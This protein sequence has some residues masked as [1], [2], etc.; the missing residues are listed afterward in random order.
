MHCACCKNTKA[1]DD[2]A[3]TQLNAAYQSPLAPFPIA[4]CQKY[5]T[6]LAYPSY[7]MDQAVTTAPYLDT[8]NNMPLPALAEGAASHGT[9]QAVHNFFLP[10]SGLLSHAQAPAT[11][12]WSMDPLHSASHT[13]PLTTPSVPLVDGNGFS[14]TVGYA[15]V[16]LPPQTPRCLLEAG[17]EDPVIADT[18]AITNSD[19]V[20]S[21]RVRCNI[22]N[23]DFGKPN[24][25]R[26]HQR[27]VH[28]VGCSTTFQCVCAY[29]N[30]RKDNFIRH[31][32]RCSDA[33]AVYLYYACICQALFEDKKTYVDHVVSCR[34]NSL[35][36]G[37]RSANRVCGSKTIGYGAAV[38]NTV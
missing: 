25:L 6:P 20:L 4:N 30:V 3:A 21:S 35:R 12:I 27:Q 2:R 15:P 31:L 22:C 29:R 7:Q 5:N 1:M 32:R 19:T 8:P 37:R 14:D 9:M 10:P 28:G 33:S 13:A 26:R 34:F 36:P 17:R 18:F 24:D 38:Q 23:K 11:P 16:W